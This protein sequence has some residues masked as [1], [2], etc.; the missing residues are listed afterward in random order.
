MDPI[1]ERRRALA[2]KA[3]DDKLAELHRAPVRA[4]LQPIASGPAASPPAAGALDAAQQQ[5]QQPSA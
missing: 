3:I 4:V 2:M 5:Q 1:A